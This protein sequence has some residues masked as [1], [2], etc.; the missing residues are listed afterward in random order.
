[1]KKKIFCLFFKKINNLQKFKRY[2]GIIGK[3]IYR[4]ISEKAWYMWIKK[5]TILIN[6]YKLNMNDKN[7]IKK[8][9]KYMITFLFK[10]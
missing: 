2:P 5:Q 4:N 3:I 6:E 1:M 9:E 8:I 7:N 10:K